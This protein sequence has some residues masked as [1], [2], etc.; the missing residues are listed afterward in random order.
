MMVYILDC[1]SLP[2]NH[3]YITCMLITEFPNLA[4]AGT[5]ISYTDEPVGSRALSLGYWFKCTVQF[6]RIKGSCTPGNK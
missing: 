5:I 4:W 2:Y 3:R 6:N 1:Y